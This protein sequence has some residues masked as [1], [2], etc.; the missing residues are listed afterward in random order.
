MPGC[1]ILDLLLTNT[2]QWVRFVVTSPRDDDDDICDLSLVMKRPSVAIRLNGCMTK[3]YLQSI[4]LHELF[5]DSDSIIS[6]RASTDVEPQL[7]QC[8]SV[9]AFASQLIGEK[10]D[11]SL[12]LLPTVLNA[13]VHTATAPAP[14]VPSGGRG[15]DCESDMLGAVAAQMHATLHSINFPLVFLRYRK[16]E[17]VCCFKYVRIL[18]IY[19]FV[20]NN[21]IT[22]MPTYD[23]RQFFGTDTTQVITFYLF[24]QTLKIINF[25]HSTLHLQKFIKSR[26]L[27]EI[28]IAGSP[29]HLLAWQMICVRLIVIDN[30]MLNATAFEQPTLKV[31]SDLL[32]ISME[33]VRYR[34]S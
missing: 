25:H 24:K 31:L 33:E 4:L 1:R 23:D 26:K 13:L 21:I 28:I 32:D 27:L 9:V 30:F 18:S 7:R 6:N 19:L 22:S 10:I 14:A 11:Y 20:N 5:H 29:H 15:K 8:G 12:A 16:C 17:F 3:D 2:P 34:Y